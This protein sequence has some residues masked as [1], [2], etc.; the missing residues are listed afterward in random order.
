MLIFSLV[1][2]TILESEGLV[3]ANVFARFGLLGEHL[4]NAIAGALG[5][6]FIALILFRAAPGN[7]RLRLWVI[8]IGWAASFLISGMI[9]RSFVNINFSI[10]VGIGMGVAGLIGSWV[11]LE[12]IRKGPIRRPNW[13]LVGVSMLGSTVGALL[14]EAIFT[15]AY[16]I[17]SVPF[18]LLGFA[19]WGLMVGASLGVPSRNIRRISLLGGAGAAGM[20]IGVLIWYFWVGFDTTIIWRLDYLHLHTDIILCLGLG[21][22]LVL[23]LSTQRISAALIL[24][25]VGITAFM[26][27]SWTVNN[28]Q[29]P[30]LWLRAIGVG[31]IIGGFLGLAW[32]YLEKPDSSNSN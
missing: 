12:A 32:V 31:V 27:A 14:A 29:Y 7:S 10:V 8:S 2:T 17:E 25:I 15:V 19:I 26:M 21:F 30:N 5:G 9:T 18:G 1:I 16:P 24:A 11:T 23:G 6:L 4:R 20:L 13:I 22:G 28:W 3:F